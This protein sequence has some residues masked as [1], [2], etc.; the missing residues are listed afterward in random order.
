MLHV[1]IV[2]FCLLGA[3]EKDFLQSPV[4]IRLKQVA[5]ASRLSRRSC[6][7]RPRI[8]ARH[9]TPL[10]DSN[11]QTKVDR[12]KGDEEG[13]DDSKDVEKDGKD[14]SKKEK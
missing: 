9:W 3:F 14:D 4:M 11:A 13:K 12:I 1:F 10:P 8:F 6:L 7:V 5:I 2:C